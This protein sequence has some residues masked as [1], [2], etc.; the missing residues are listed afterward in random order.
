MEL[1]LDSCRIYFLGLRCREWKAGIVR[2]MLSFIFWVQS[3]VNC[4][5]D[6]KVHLGF[7]IRC[8]GKSLM[9]FLA[10]SID[11]EWNS[12]L[13]ILEQWL[14]ESLIKDHLQRCGQGLGKI[15]IMV[16]CYG[17]CSSRELLLSLT[18]WGQ[19]K[20]EEGNPE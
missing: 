4:W 9:K 5:V 14:E 13:R 1:F 3:Y 15:T 11:G 12:L 2:V 20:E 7:S 10:N 19:K 17:S 16:L 8:L 6:Q 18:L